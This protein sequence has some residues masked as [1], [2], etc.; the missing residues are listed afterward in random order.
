[1]RNALIADNQD[2]GFEASDC[3]KLGGTITSQGHNLVSNANGCDYVSATG[4]II[5]RE[6]GLLGLNYNGG[7]T[8]TNALKS[9]SPAIN[10]G[11]GC[12]PKDQ[13]GVERTS[14]C[15]IGAWELA[16]CQGAVINR[17]GTESADLLTGTSGRD[18]ILGL[19]GQD[20]LRGLGGNDGLCGGKGPDVLGGGPGKDGLDGGPG[21]D[22]CLGATA[23]DKLAKC[24]L[25]KQKKNKKGK[26]G[27]R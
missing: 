23:K 21:K 6:A 19:G 27:R 4:D 5:N 20:T 3:A 11:A 13:R 16:Y 15:D 22:N 26:K 17:I 1:M 7:P 18:G 2:N 14:K 10:K 25:P 12:P 8:W 24:E 9:I